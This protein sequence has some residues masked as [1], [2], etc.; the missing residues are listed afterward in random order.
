MGLCGFSLQS[1]GDDCESVVYF[2]SPLASNRKY[3]PLPLSRAG[4]WNNGM[5]SMHYYVFII[6]YTRSRMALKFIQVAV[7]CIRSLRNHWQLPAFIVKIITEKVWLVLTRFEVVQFGVHLPGLPAI[8]LY[9]SIFRNVKFPVTRWVTT[10]CI[11]L[12]PAMQ[13]SSALQWSLS[14]H[15]AFRW[16]WSD[17]HECITCQASC[18]RFALLV[19]VWGPIQ[20]KDAVL[21]V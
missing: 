20:Y 17:I 19:V 8:E 1:S 13:S 9:S 4:S 7:L 10:W 18:T 21:P 3:G 11:W 14:N 15:D 5:R 6:W 12:V 16:S 2:I